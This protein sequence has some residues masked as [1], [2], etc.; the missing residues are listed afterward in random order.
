MCDEMNLNEIRNNGE[1]GAGLNNEGFSHE[2]DNVGQQALPNCN[3]RTARIK[4]RKEVNVV[5]MEC[6]YLSKPVEEND[7]PIR[8]YRQR[9]FKKWQDRGMFDSTK[10][11]IC[12]QARAIRKN[13]W[14]TNVELEIIKRRVLEE[15]NSESQDMEEIQENVDGSNSR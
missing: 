7:R 4:W 8:G 9:M 2:R 10:Q 11:S 3:Q 13:G 5:I 15:E 14:L 6:Y 1:N 12:K